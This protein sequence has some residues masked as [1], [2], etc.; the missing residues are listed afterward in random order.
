MKHRIFDSVYGEVMLKENYDVDDCCTRI[1]VY[2]GDNYDQW[3]GEISCDINDD[4][5][6]E[7]AL[8]EIF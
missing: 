6:I 2:I 1:D 7:R 5:A 4:S 8:D 3:V